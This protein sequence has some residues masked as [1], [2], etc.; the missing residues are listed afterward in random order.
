MTVEVTKNLVYG[1]GGG[2][3][4]LVD[5]YRP[6]RPNGAGVLMVHGGGWRMGSREMV[7]G[8]AEG[9]CEAGFTC[10]ACEYRFTPESPWPAQI[11]DVKAAM[12]WFRAGAP[13]WDLDPNRL[14]VLGNSAGGHLALMLA[15]TVGEPRFEGDGGNPG[16]DT[17]V[18]AVIA[19]FP[20]VSFYVGERS[21]GSTNA[22]A[23]LG[24]DPDPEAASLASPIR[25]ARADFP[26]TFLLHGNGD[27]VVPVTASI[28]LYNA[29]VQAG[30][31][32]EMH[33][34]A[35]QP[36]SWARWPN[37]T[38]PTMAE[39]SVFLERYMLEGDRYAAPA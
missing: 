16:V 24:A 25:Y 8:Q 26:P 14:A 28:N 11:H 27:K 32:A 15:G 18:A 33:I 23:I 39:A 31:V 3:D 12:R 30:A 17:S 6:R 4:L 9:L 20:A 36:H 29:L 37:W 13:G 1:T 21:S 38:G 2:R 7:T 19:V 5:L 10:A 35:E 34:Y 22:E